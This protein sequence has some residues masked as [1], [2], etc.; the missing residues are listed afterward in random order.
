MTVHGC[1]VRSPAKLH[2]SHVT[3]SRD[4]QK[5]RPI[6]LLHLWASVACYRLIFTFISY[7]FIY[8]YI[9]NP[10][11]A[12]KWE[13]KHFKVLFEMSRIQ[14]SAQKSLSFMRVQVFFTPWG[15]CR[16]NSIIRNCNV[17][18]SF[19]NFSSSPIV[20]ELGNAAE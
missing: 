9:Y 3:G 12:L 11:V 20:L 1:I 19:H 17:T 18:D 8:I 2:Q 5:S 4:I 14:I 7:I 10:D 16:D 6:P 15:K 13:R